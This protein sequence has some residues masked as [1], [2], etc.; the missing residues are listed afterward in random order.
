MWHCFRLACRCSSVLAKV[1]VLLTLMGFVN[2]CIVRVGETW[3]RALSLGASSALSDVSAVM[4]QK[5][6]VV[7]TLSRLVPT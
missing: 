4:I 7:L 6:G 2:D 3:H 1:A 5:L